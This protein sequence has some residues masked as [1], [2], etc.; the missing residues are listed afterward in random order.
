MK[1]LP[2]AVVAVFLCLLFPYLV[3]ANPIPIIQYQAID[4]PDLVPGQ[5]LWQYQYSV[6]Y[7]TADKFLQNQAFTIFFDYNLYNNLEDPPPILTD[8]FTFVF[9]PDLQLPSDGEYDAL[10][11][12]DDPSLANAFNLTFVWLGGAGSAPGS[13][14]F[15]VN[16]FDS[17]G[18][19]VAMLGS[20]QTNLIP[21]PATLLLVAGGLAALAVARR[22]KR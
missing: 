18:N 6:S 16:E 11:L 14:P 1:R 20:G 22:R 13:Q 5:D 9:Q 10:A 2:F 21:E 19:F 4:F 17:Q 12:K 3:G 8:W 7:A 15:V